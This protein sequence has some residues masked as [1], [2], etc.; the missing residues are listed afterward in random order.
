MKAGVKRQFGNWSNVAPIVIG[1]LV[2]GSIWGL[3]DAISTGALFAHI[4]P[5]LKS[6]QICICPLTGAVFGFFIMALALAIYKKP[7]M[8]IG[9]GAV[10]ALF[11]LLNFAIIPLPVVQG[12]V[13]YQPVVNP[14]LAAFASSLVF[15]L[16]ATLLLNRLESNVPI[17]VGAGI[18]A[19]FLAVVVFVYAAFYVTHTH[20]LIV[21]TP[22]QFIAPLH[23]LATAALGAIFFPLGYAAGVKLRGRASSLLAAR[24]RFYY[25][26]SGVTVFCIGISAAALTVA[27]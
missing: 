10:A 11:K 21:D 24:P 1:I 5:T 20:P 17:R 16:V 27:L 18:L 6:H 3:L 22:W 9:I 7:A 25:L 26:G 23:G 14:A 15:A 13:A 12:N 2:F 4:A 8:L 19:G